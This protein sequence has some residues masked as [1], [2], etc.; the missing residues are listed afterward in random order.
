MCNLEIGTQFPDSENAQH[1]LKIVQTHRLWGIHIHTL[2]EKAAYAARFVALYESVDVPLEWN[3][4]MEYW[5]SLNCYK[6]LD[7]YSI[8]FLTSSTWL[9]SQFRHPF[10][11]VIRV[12][13]HVHIGQ[14]WLWLNPARH[15]T[16]F[17][18]P[19][20][21]S[22]VSHGSHAWL[23]G[24]HHCQAFNWVLQLEHFA[25]IR[26]YKSTYF[27]QHTLLKHNQIYEYDWS[28]LICT[29][30]LSHITPGKTLQQAAY[31]L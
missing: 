20:A 16:G 2:A 9:W 21:V 6:I 30:A 18:H 13:G 14:R 25:Y 10:L 26:E 29:W 3:T 12:K 17:E 7:N 22:T 5:N 19:C 15:A 31:Q 27:E 24:K 28:S 4:G 11:E 8:T 1:N 23:S